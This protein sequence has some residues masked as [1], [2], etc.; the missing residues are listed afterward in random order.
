MTLGAHSTTSMAV[1]AVVKEVKSM[2]STKFNFLAGMPDFFYDFDKGVSDQFKQYYAKI[3]ADRRKN[4]WIA[5]SY[6]YQSPEK[7]DV[8][9]RNGFCY[10]R[11]LSN[12]VARKIYFQ[13][14]KLPLLFSI[15]TTDSKYLNEVSNFTGIRFDWSFTCKYKDLLWPLWVPNANYPLG[16]YIRPSVP[17]GYLYKCTK[18]GK[19]GNTEPS[20]SIDN[21][22]TNDNEVEWTSFVPD[23]LLVKA[24]DFSRNDTIINN[25]IENGIMYQYDFGFTLY[26]TDYDDSGELAGYIT[27]A[28]LKL[29][30]MDNA[31]LDTIRVPNT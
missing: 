2:L 6:S 26:Y 11:K 17:N 15:L 3:P 25:P 16:W 1:K 8:Q 21:T 19:S 12:S 24:A 22:I 31:V 13:Y 27:E 29:L 7:S 18:L 9:S 23:D 14:V 28:E 5:L 30:N 4:P 20:W 10:F